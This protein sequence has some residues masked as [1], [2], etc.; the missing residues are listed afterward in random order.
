[1]GKAERTRQYIVERTAPLFNRKGFDGTSL[2]DLTHATG[3]TKGALYGNFEDKEEI[4]L[5]AFH[6]SVKKVRKLVMKELV[7]I[8]HPREQLLAILKFYSQY[9]FSPPVP[10][11]C[12]LLNTAVEADD[13]RPG[14]RKIVALELM[15]TVEFLRRVIVRGK[16]EGVF[17]KSVNSREFA[18]SL[19]C[20]VEGALMFSRVERSQEPMN[21]VIRHAKKLLDDITI[22]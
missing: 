20:L 16:R 6:Y 12:P 21:L 18:F 10:G 4:A 1:M 3:L 17:V 13:H 2:T 7:G 15:H 22:K 5:E 19:F 14:M 9:V 8:T 11:G